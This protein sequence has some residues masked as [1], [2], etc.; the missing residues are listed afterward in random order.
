MEPYKVEPGPLTTS[1][2]SP[3]SIIDSIN[4]FTF[5]K[6]GDLRG[7][8]SSKY[9]KLPAPAPPDNTGDLIEVRC[10]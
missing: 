7:I 2:L 9:K 8:P 6:P 5:P 4:P 1:A 10:S 3:I